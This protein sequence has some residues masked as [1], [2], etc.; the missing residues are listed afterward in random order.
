[1]HE[2]P[3][4]FDRKSISSYNVSFHP[5]HPYS[6]LYIDCRRGLFRIKV[7]GIFIAINPKILSHIFFF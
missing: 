3:Q 5:F 7:A 2:I 4:K 1:M 6:S